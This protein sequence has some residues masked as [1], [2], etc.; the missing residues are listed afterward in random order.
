M[1]PILYCSIG[2][3]IF[4][5]GMLAGSLLE[6]YRRLREVSRNPPPLPRA[7]VIVVGSDAEAEAA[8]ER[9]WRD[10]PDAVV[11]VGP[12]LIAP[13]QEAVP[14]PA[15]PSAGAVLR[16]ARPRGGAAAGTRARRPAPCGP[17]QRRNS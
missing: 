13:P 14:M 16:R 4:L 7:D 2:L 10:G 12:S 9:V 1:A 17:G 3:I 8:V 15:S 6:S 5:L 11:T